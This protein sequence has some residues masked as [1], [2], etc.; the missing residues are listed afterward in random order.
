MKESSR[1]SRPRRGF[2]QAVEGED[3][4]RK[5]ASI[6]EMDEAVMRSR[7]EGGS[8]YSNAND[9]TVVGKASAKARAEPFTADAGS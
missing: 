1:E 7:G 3:P 2:C 5:P 8:P 6:E 9:Q 4:K